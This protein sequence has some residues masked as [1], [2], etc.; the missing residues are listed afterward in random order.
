MVCHHIAAMPI[1]TNKKY[2][3]YFHQVG[4][5]GINGDSQ[6]MVDFAAKT[7]ELQNII[8]KQVIPLHQTH[9]DLVHKLRL[10]FVCADR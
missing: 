2:F 3:F 4:A 9:F 1:E 6:E 7:H 8:E 5:Q 10:S